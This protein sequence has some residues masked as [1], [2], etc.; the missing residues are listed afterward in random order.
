[1]ADIGVCRFGIG[2][3]E[4]QV[5]TALSSKPRK[6]TGPSLLSENVEV[7]WMKISTKFR[8]GPLFLRRGRSVF[9]H[10]SHGRRSPR[11]I[12][13]SLQRGDIQRCRS[14]RLESLGSRRHGQSF[15]GIDETEAE[16]SWVAL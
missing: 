15:K 1:M 8:G 14:R 5:N 7:P 6:T 11:G 3:W 13:G 10:I 12:R 4:Q 9:R 16:Q 2:W